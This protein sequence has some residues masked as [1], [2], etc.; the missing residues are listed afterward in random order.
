LL[1]KGRKKRCSSEKHSKKQTLAN[2]LRQ[3]TWS[4][5]EPAGAG[6]PE[7]LKA[8]RSFYFVNDQ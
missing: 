4:W 5:N 7:K 6:L 1:I 2:E 3:K 8:A